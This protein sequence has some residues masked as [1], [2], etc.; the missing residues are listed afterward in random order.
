MFDGLIERLENNFDKSMTS[1]MQRL[2]ASTV[3]FKKIANGY[4]QKKYLER[5][6]FIEFLDKDVLS[7][8]NKNDDSDDYQSADEG[9]VTDDDVHGEENRR[10]TIMRIQ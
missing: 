4:T 1:Q 10:R 8:D 6:S 2:R 7:T 5:E 3:A 9:E